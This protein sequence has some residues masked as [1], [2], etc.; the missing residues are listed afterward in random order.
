MQLLKDN[1]D[2]EKMKKQKKKCVIKRKFKFQNYKN[3][4]EAATQLDDKI[5]H[6]EKCKIYADN[7][8]EDEKQFI[9]NSK[10]NKIKTKYRSEKHNIFTE[11][12]DK[13]AL[14]SDDHKIM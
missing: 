9:I 2:E 1:K 14:H 7:F 4:L 10:Q 11:E 8:K 12:T 3:C 6:L 13:I 5:N